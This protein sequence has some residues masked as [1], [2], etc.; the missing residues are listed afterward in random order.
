[1]LFTGAING[2]PIR[3]ELVIGETNFELIAQEILKQQRLMQELEA[4]NQELR[5]QLA[6]LRAGRG[7]HR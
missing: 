2:A 5:R 4:E 1:M 7:R 3:R 6:D